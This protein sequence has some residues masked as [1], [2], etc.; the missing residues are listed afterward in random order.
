MSSE[1]ADVVHA[2]LT[3]AN[4]GDVDRVLALTA[5]EIV[6]IGPRGRAAGHDVLRA[7]LASAGA[8]F[9]TRRRF[10][11]GPAVVVA[12]HGVWR[13]AASGTIVGEAA[14]A[15]R[16]VVQAGRVAE[17]ERFDRLEDALGAA[18][19]GVADEIPGA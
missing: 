14:V 16:F 12:Q 17:L 1:P 2:W 15:T 5:P 6:L 4:A 3:A 18:G 8:R 9:E 11:R 7:W 10:A 13:D 19:L